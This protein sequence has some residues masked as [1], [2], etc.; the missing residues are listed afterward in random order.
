MKEPAKACVT[1]LWVLLWFG[2]A[3]IWVEG[4]WAVSVLEAGA[5]ALSAAVLLRRASIRGHWALWILVAIA[6]WGALQL[7][8]G[9]TL[10]AAQTE[11]AILYWLV[12]ACFFGLGMLTEDRGYSL[13]ELLWS[14]AGR[15]ALPLPQP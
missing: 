12:A 8:L 11:W 6:A 10:A 1:S 13:N 3:T 15:S 14:A 5:F 2:I 9:W 4:R 7:A